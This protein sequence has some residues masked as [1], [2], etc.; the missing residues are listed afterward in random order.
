MGILTGCRNPAGALLRGRNTH[1]PDRRKENE[2]EGEERRSDRKREE[3]K[4]QWEKERTREKETAGE[5][6]REYLRMRLSH[7]F[8]MFA[9]QGGC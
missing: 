7:R 1:S 2:R 8:K 3:G 6:A 9:S 5:R 4:R